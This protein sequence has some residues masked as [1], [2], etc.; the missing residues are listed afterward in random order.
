MP[1]GGKR[2]NAGRKPKA[3]EIKLIES[4]DKVAMP[5]HVIELLWG[6]CLEG[7]VRAIKLWFEYR[8]GMPKQKVDITTDGEKIAPPV[9]WIKSDS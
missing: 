9:Q 4:M 1:A 7:D 6:K 3:D 5:D 2:E 8:F